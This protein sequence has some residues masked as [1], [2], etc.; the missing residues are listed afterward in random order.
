MGYQSGKPAAKGRDQRSK[1]MNANVRQLAAR[2]FFRLMF[3]RGAQAAKKSAPAKRGA[4]RPSILDKRLTAI[5]AKMTR[6]DGVKDGSPQRARRGFL[7][8][9]TAQKRPLID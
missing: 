7:C 4:P 9:E 3:A 1:Q 5:Q 2:A 6:Q 8:C